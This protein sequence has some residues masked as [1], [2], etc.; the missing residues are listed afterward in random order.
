MQNLT[1]KT[2]VAINNTLNPMIGPDSPI[3]KN[4][5]TDEANEFIRAMK[6]QVNSV[7]DEQ[8]KIFFLN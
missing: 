8:N 7:I 2:E 6:D 3:T 1:E 5:K 4:L